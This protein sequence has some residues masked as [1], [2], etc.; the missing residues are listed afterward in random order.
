[1]VESLLGDC[2]CEWIENG[3]DGRSGGIIMMWRQGVLVPE[4]SFKSNGFLGVKAN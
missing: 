4:F 3:M 2:F 1:M